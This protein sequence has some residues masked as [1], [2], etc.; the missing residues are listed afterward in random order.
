MTPSKLLHIIPNLPVA[1]KNILT[2]LVQAGDAEFHIPG[3]PDIAPSQWGKAS[4]ALVRKA[5][6]NFEFEF[7]Q[8]MGVKVQVKGRPSGSEH[9]LVTVGASVTETLDVSNPVPNVKI[10]PVLKIGDQGGDR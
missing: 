9:T 4:V 7:F 6:E 2:Q 8:T 1:S 5:L 3:V 10:V